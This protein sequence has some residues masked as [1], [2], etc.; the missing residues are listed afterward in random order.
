[1]LLDRVLSAVQCRHGRTAA[2]CLLV[3]LVV[4]VP[5][6]STTPPDPL[7]IGGI[8]DAADD[9]DVVLAV[10]SL[11]VLVEEGLALARSVSLVVGILVPGHMAAPG[12]AALGAVQPRAPPLSSVAPR[13]HD[14]T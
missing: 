4:L 5:L 1:M 8:Y 11:E 13:H 12:S 3:V 9:D 7:W 14:R 6:A 10:V 2:L